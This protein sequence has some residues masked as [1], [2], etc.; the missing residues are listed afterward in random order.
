MA[1]PGVQ[2]VLFGTHM[3]AEEAEYLWDNTHQ[4]LEAAC[5]KIT[6]ESFKIAFLEKYFLTDVRSKKEIKLLS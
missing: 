4:R 2:K 5:T 1:C 3:L 6:W